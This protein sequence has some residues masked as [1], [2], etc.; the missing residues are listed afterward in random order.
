MLSMSK[1]LRIR[2]KP[3][4]WMPEE[5]SAMTTSPGTILVLSMIFFLSTMPTLK[6]A[7]SYSSTGIM[8]GCSAVSP[9]IRAEPA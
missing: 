3:L 9:P 2:E 1:T 8:P 6:P 4:E 7:R 5:A